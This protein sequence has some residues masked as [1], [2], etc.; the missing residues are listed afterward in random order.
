ML[1]S[2]IVSK[3]TNIDIYCRCY[4]VVVSKLTVQMGPDGTNE[5]VMAKV[6]YKHIIQLTDCHLLYSFTYNRLL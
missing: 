6:E 2:G 4:E 1:W 3:L 5:E